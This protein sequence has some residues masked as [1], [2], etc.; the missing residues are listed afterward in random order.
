MVQ[1][2]TNHMKKPLSCA[3]LI[4][5]LVNASILVFAVDFVSAEAPGVIVIIGSDTTWTKADSPHVL[6]GP[7]F[8]SEGSVL[9]IEAGCNL[10]LNGYY[11][12]VNGTFVAVGTGSERI[13]IE[14]GERLEFTEFSD[15]WN[16]Q[17]KSGCVIDEAYI[18]CPVYSTVSLK[19]N[20]CSLPSGVTVGDSSIIANCEIEG[21]VEAG[22]SFSLSDSSVSGTLNSLDSSMITN[23]ILEGRVS[24]GNSSQILDNT[25]T[26]D[27]Y[28]DYCVVS[29]N[30]IDGDTVIAEEISNNDITARHINALVIL[31]NHIIGN[32]TVDD[33]AVVS[34]NYIQ[35]GYTFIIPDI[36]AF[37]GFRTGIKV[38]Y[39][40]LRIR[41]GSPLISNNVI[42]GGITASD[43]DSPTILN[44]T[45]LNSGIYFPNPTVVPPG[46]IPGSAPSYDTANS[47]V[48]TNNTVADIINVRA[49]SC[50]IS[51]NI[52]PRIIASGGSAHIYDNVIEDGAGIGASSGGIIER[53]YLFRNSY[54]IG[55]GSSGSV[56]IR[57]NTIIGNDVGISLSSNATVRNNTITGSQIGIQVTDKSV[58]ATIE[59]N[60]LSNNDVGLQIGS[61]TI[62]RNNTITG[63]NI[64]ITLTNDPSVTVQYN[65]IEGYSQYSICLENS[66]NNFDVSNNWWG[67]V[68]TQSINISIRDYK[69]DFDLGKVSFT[70]FLTEPNSQATSDPI[71]EFPSWL[72]LPLFLVATF[73]VAVVRKKVLGGN[74]K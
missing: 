60:F 10:D 50:N 70:T 59:R 22:G 30:S 23:N 54:G 39:G 48:I 73:V 57:D 53:N 68:D 24:I 66:S 40:A 38:E 63:A 3:V 9:T 12:L 49:Y 42:D 36:P 64:A 45:I 1:T 29:S 58:S 47:L 52:V 43:P 46:V 44:N 7:L 6:T 28:A 21:N 11:I 16:E 14:N 19:L 32:V 67:T 13:H 34:N 71:P 41:S 72:L 74:C 31:D 27:V 35:G 33:S 17:T 61:Q 56:I 26:A 25:I 15:G 2:E 65:N 37:G 4:T 18:A 5:L 20:A 55:G 69:Y 8:V 62:I 51:G